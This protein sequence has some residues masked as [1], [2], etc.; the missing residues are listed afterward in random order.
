[1]KT[2]RVI[3]RQY[4]FGLL[5]LPFVLL[6]L[7][8]V[9]KWVQGFVIYEPAYFSAEYLERYEVPNELLMDAEIAFRQG[10]AARMPFDSGAFDFAVSSGSLHHWSKPASVFDEIHRVLRPGQP[11]LVY[12]LR[13]DAP[14]EKVEEVSRHVKSRFMRWGLRH[15][16]AE[17]YT[18]ETVQGLLS[19]TRF[20]KAERIDLD[21]LGMFIWLR[22]E[23]EATTT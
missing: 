12:D 1:M 19:R 15:S 7:A 5:L 23:G 20:G 18:P 4:V 11:A 14:K 9:V 6:A 3:D 16:I 22:K 13:R 8:F 10:D 17:A 21:D 2:Q